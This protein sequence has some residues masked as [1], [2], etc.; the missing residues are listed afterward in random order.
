MIL[1]IITFLC[2]SVSLA[3]SQDGKDVAIQA[4]IANSSGDLYYVYGFKR[5]TIPQ[6]ALKDTGLSSKD[7]SAY[8][9]KQWPAAI[10]EIRGILYAL[11][12]RAISDLKSGLQIKLDG[13]KKTIQSIADATSPL[14][15]HP[16]ALIKVIERTMQACGHT[17]VKA[18]ASFKP[19]EDDSPYR[20]CEAIDISGVASQPCEFSAFNK[21]IKIWLDLPQGQAKLM[22]EVIA[23]QIKQKKIPFKQ[24]WKLEVY[25]PYSGGN[26]IAYCAL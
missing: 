15:K 24:G 22:C 23:D 13:T 25:S 11:D 14:E 2:L 4:S 3:H 16:E 26:T 21:A 1:R 17:P 5:I 8:C 18:H 10:A 20:V 7:V 19:K 9:T 12:E 6:F